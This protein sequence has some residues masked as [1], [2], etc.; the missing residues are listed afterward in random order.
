MY[1]DPIKNI[2][3]K[4]IRR[5]PLLR[6]LFYKLLD[7]MFLR[8][9]YVRNELKK[10]RLLT[11]KKELYIY[12]AGTGYGQYA[13]FMARYLQPNKIYAVDVKEE[14]IKDCDE[15]FKTDY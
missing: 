9:W 7:V 11:D 12:D 13:Y 10:I 14:W 3:A 5:H 6:I 15:F 4:V 2:F 8:S 1:Y